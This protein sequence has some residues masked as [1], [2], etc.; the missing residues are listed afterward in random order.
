[1]LFSITHNSRR[2]FAALKTD[3]QGWCVIPS[4]DMFIFFCFYNPVVPIH[5]GMASTPLRFSHPDFARWQSYGDQLYVRTLRERIKLPD[6]RIYL[7]FFAAESTKAFTH[8]GMAASS[9]T[10]LRFA[11][12]GSF[13]IQ[14]A[15]QRQTTQARR[16]YPP[17]LFEAS[18]T[19]LDVGLLRLILL[20]A[21]SCTR[22]SRTVFLQHHGGQ[23]TS[24]VSSSAFVWM[25][26]VGNRS[27]QETSCAMIHLTTQY[28]CVRKISA[29]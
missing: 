26:L 18:Y 23:S 2:W 13:C 24:W 8:S 10:R 19:S 25:L 22:I 17:P 15:D 9:I 20:H 14:C 6:F 12:W 3:G 7:M 28:V 11:G 5:F 1:M 4:S 21:C 29:A 27:M 16:S